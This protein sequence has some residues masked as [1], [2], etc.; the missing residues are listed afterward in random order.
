M[1]NTLGIDVGGTKVAF[2]LLNESGKMIRRQTIKTPESLTS[3][4]EQLPGSLAEA[5]ELARGSAFVAS[6]L[7]AGM[8]D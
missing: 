3:T 5:K 8:L 7:P 4:L 2:G 6:I 1:G